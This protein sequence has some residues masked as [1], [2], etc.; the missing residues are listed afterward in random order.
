MAFVTLQGKEYNLDLV[1]KVTTRDESLSIRLYWSRN[2]FSRLGY[3]DQG[4]YDQAKVDI[5]A[6]TGGTVDG[7]TNVTGNL[8]VGGDLTVTGKIYGVGQDEK[9]YRLGFNIN[10]NDTQD[11]PQDQALGLAFTR[12]VLDGVTGTGSMLFSDFINLPAP[13][14]Q[15][16]HVIGQVVGDSTKQSDPFTVLEVTTIGFSWDGHPGSTVDILVL[17]AESYVG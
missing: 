6:A 9:N 10:A 1:Q 2:V 13:F 8:G 16:P 4:E 14:N 3:T 15:P 17:G 11:G 7:D 5:A 12:I